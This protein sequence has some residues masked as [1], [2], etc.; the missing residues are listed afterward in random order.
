MSPGALDQQLRK[1]TK[2]IYIILIAII[3]ASIAVTIVFTVAYFL[4]AEVRVYDYIFT[5][6]EEIVYNEYLKF[7]I[8]GGLFVFFMTVPILI[9]A[10]ILHRHETFVI[11][12]N[13]VTIYSP[14]TCS[15]LYINGEL[16]DYISLFNYYLEGKTPDG[17]T[18]TVSIG[19]HNHMH[20]TF[21]NGHL[22]ID[23]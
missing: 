10:K 6:K 16:V 15:R 4:S 14:L 13:S 1:H 11:N 3:M 8:A 19:K 7:G 20:V 2:K 9:W 18:L 5:T 22:P 17:I 23:F 21:S 12:G